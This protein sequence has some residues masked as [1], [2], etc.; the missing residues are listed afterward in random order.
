MSEEKEFILSKD[1]KKLC[2]H[3][4]EIQEAERVLCLVHGLGEH[5]GRYA[6]MANYLNNAGIGMY[7]LDVRGHG[8]SD[9]KR[10]HA[11]YADLQSDI[12]ELLKYVRAI[13]TDAKLVLMGHSFGGNQVAHFVKHDTSNELAGFILSSPFF[14]VAFQPPAWKVKLAN[15]VGSLLPSLTQSNELDPQTISRDQAEVDKYVND[16]LVHDQI[17]VRMYLDVTK[18]GKNLLANEKPLRIPCLIYHGDADKL[19]SFQATEQFAAKNPS[20]IWQPLSGVFH[21]PHNDIGREQVY[22]SVRDFILAL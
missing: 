8:L 2:V 12:E 9:G 18:A 20:A 7:A 5:A 14:D 16:P 3:C 13:H 17:S 1:G 22:K 19:V 15:L 11:R 21:E 4:W 10:G 6:E